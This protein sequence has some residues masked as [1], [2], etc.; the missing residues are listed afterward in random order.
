M[1]P[2]K[3]ILNITS[4]V[5]FALVVA[6]SSAMAASSPWIEG[7]KAKAR[8]VSGGAAGAAVGSSLAFVE[9]SLEPGWKTYWRTPGDA[10]GLPPSFDWS[11]STNV[12]NA[13]VEFPAPRRFTDKSGS[14][15]GYHDEVVL[16]VTITPK[17]PG[18]PVSLVLGLHYGICKD[19]CVP[20]EAELALDLPRD[21]SEAIPPEIEEA[22]KQIPRPQDKLAAGD[23]VLV[24][25]TAKL[26]GADPKISIEARF[27]D[28][29][30][31]ADAFVEA[32]DGAL[33]PLPQQVG[34]ADSSG[35]ALFE[36]SLGADV[37]LPG[38]KG[39]TL[40]VTLVSDTGASYAT[41][42]AE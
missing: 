26:D 8:L 12:A 21:E 6:S 20:V 31:A 7:H 3:R 33:I 24:A 11:N 28:G 22:L 27:P 42:I 37:D 40:T 23:P 39:K 10:G 16:P 41:F 18:A 36:V 25:A 32:P 17:D 38:L 35:R 14:T 29:A 9:I 34:D 2:K 13:T 15:I 30:A 4:N 5:I 1:R 19:I